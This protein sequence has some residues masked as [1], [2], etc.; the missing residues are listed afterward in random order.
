MSVVLLRGYP[1]VRCAL[2][3]VLIDVFCSASDVGSLI[4]HWLFYSHNFA[5]NLFQ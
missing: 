5:P 4:S 2:V 1:S 3:E